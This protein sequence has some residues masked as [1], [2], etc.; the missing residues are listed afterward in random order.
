MSPPMTAEPVI[1][2]SRPSGAPVIASFTVRSTSCTIGTFCTSISPLVS[3]ATTIAE[4]ISGLPWGVTS[5]SLMTSVRR[6]HRSTSAA[7]SSVARSASETFAICKRSSSF[8]GSPPRAKTSTIWLRARSFGNASFS[9]L[10]PCKLVTCL[11]RYS[12]SPSRASSFQ[13]FAVKCST[14]AITS[15]AASPAGQ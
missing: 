14:S 5:I 9:S 15:H 6:S 8:S 12:R 7:G 3:L 11:G 10:S 4:T 1:P 13:L 2:T